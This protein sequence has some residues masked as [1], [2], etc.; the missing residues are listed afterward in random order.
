MGYF[1]KKQGSFNYTSKKLTAGRFQKWRW[2]EDD[3]PFQKGVF[4]VPAVSFLGS[5]YLGGM[6]LDAIVW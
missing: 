1:M 6:K 5:T 3:F 4:Q 2:M